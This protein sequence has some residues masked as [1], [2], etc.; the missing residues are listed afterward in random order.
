MRGY[1]LPTGW[2]ARA[3]LSDIHPITGRAL[4]RAVCW[5]IETKE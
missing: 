3:D 1:R 2:T 4:V 5:I